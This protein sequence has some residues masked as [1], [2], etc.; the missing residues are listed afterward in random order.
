MTNEA[1]IREGLKD[2]D[3][4]AI[5]DATC[6]PLK[7]PARLALW[8][9]VRKYAPGGIFQATDSWADV[10]E[11]VSEAALIAPLNAALIHGCIRKTRERRLAKD[12]TEDAMTKLLRSVK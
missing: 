11:G 10:A 4:L 8:A 7:L 3:A 1:I 2:T 9:N 5:L 6:Q 12:V